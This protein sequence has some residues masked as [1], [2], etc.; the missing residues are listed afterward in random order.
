MAFKYGYFPVFFLDFLKQFITNLEFI[1]KLFS[2]LVGSHPNSSRVKLGRFLGGVV[3]KIFQS[4]E[5]YKSFRKGSVK[6]LWKKL[7]H[8]SQIHNGPN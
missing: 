3:S 8:C 1:L 5:V 4:S 6:G 7:S 2:L